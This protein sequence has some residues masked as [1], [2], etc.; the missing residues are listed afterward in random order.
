MYAIRSYYVAGCPGLD[1]QLFIFIDAALPHPFKEGVNSIAALW[2]EERCG[3][4]PGVTKR[5]AD[6]AVAGCLPQP[7][8]R[9]L[10]RQR[11]RH[12]RARH[13]DR[14]VQSDLPGATH[15]AGTDGSGDVITSYSIHYTK[16]YEMPLA[17]SA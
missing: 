1:Q 6:T 17:A 11:R 14:F 7:D 2:I 10:E 4:G 12:L 8:Q 5:G 9:V 13:S 15:R 3:H 16:L